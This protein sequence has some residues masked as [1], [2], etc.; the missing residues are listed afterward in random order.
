MNYTSTFRNDCGDRFAF[1]YD[2]ET[3]I[4]WL[5]GSDYG[6]EP[7]PIVDGV[8]QGAPILGVDEVAWLAEEWSKATG[9]ELRTKAFATALADLIKQAESLGGFDGEA[10]P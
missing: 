8:V 6:D 3:G 5:S 7:L 4:G 10:L 9:T 2:P 1:E